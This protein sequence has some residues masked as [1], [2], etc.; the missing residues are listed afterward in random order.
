MRQAW[1]AS[2]ST[3]FSFKSQCN[4]IMF[5][6]SFWISSFFGWQILRLKWASLIFSGWGGIIDTVESLRIKVPNSNQNH[7]MSSPAIFV[8]SESTVINIVKIS[9]MCSMFTYKFMYVFQEYVDILWEY[10]HGDWS[11]NTWVS[12]L[13]A[14]FFGILFSEAMAIPK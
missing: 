11:S 6:C 10:V 14:R 3:I 12:H 8:W 1:V 4:V 9:S 2:K 13:F 7:V 5:L